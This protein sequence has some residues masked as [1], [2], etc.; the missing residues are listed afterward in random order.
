M[1]RY[2]G[3]IGDSLGG[4]TEHQCPLQENPHVVKPGVFTFY[5]FIK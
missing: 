3:D 1:K 2:I 4:N 5:C